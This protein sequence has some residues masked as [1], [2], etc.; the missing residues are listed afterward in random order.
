MGGRR[1]TDRSVDT[2]DWVELVLAVE[3]LAYD[4]HQVK[5]CNVIR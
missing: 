5:P 4:V 1:E 3:H 2:E